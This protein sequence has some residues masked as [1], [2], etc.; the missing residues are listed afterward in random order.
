M[1]KFAIILATLA[2]AAAFPSAASATQPP[3]HKVTICH[4]TGSTTNPTVEI[5]VDIAAAQAHLDHHG[6]V[7]GP[8]P[9]TP[10][11][12][13]CPPP[14]EVKVPVIVTVP[15]PAT[16]VPGPV[17]VVTAPAVT[18]TQVVV[19]ARK[20][21]KCERRWNAKHTKLVVVCRRKAVTP[22]GV[23]KGRKTGS[24]QAPTLTG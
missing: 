24:V 10:G 17:Q 2:A 7:I 16:T 9:E 3:Q 5:T 15:G 19:V 21:M 23:K 4:Q 13:P 8:C 12:V 20:K 6:D 11:P 22:P 14:T 18:K 1:K